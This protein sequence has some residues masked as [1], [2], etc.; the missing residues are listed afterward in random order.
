MLDF[1]VMLQLEG[2]DCLVVGQ[3]TEA[4]AKARRLEVAG[5]RVRRL[6]V[7]DRA[8]AGRPFLIVAD[9]PAPEAEQVWRFAEE[10]GILLNVVDKP[11]YCNFTFPAVL[12]RGNLRIA[13]STCGIAPALAGWIRDRLAETLSEN[14]SGLLEVLHR[15]RPAIVRHLPDWETR[16]NFYR[17][18]ATAFL[19]SAPGQAPSQRGPGTGIQRIEDPCA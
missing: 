8:G 18:L 13:V 9:L 2:R 7:F 4:T 14:W 19:H 12:E 1:P 15:L 17:S 11:D 5:A 6:P 16:K 3:T 10:Q